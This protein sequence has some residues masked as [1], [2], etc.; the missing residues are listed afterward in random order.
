MPACSDQIHTV[1]GTMSSFVANNEPSV[2]EAMM[3]TPREG[4]IVL[5][6]DIEVGGLAGCGAMV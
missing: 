4:T 2:L 5:E 1:V 6:E 3:E